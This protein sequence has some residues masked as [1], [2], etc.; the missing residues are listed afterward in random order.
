[1]SADQKKMA[2]IS[3]E[4]YNNILTENKDKVEPLDANGISVGDMSDG[5]VKSLRALIDVYLSSI[6]DALAKERLDQINEEDFSKVVFAW[7]GATEQFKAHYYRIQGSSFLIEF[8]NAQNNSNHIHTVW[9][10][11]DGDFG[12]DLIKA[13]RQAHKH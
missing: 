2:V 6:P 3:S 12:E 5:Q 7:A 8:D 4:A 13:H 10:D 1:M 9:R 11:F